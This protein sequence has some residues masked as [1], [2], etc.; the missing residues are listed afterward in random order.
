MRLLLSIL[1]MGWQ[2]HAAQAQELFTYT[3]P[4]SNMPAKNIGIRLTSTIMYDPVDQ[5]NN[6]HLLPELMVGVS[7]NWMMHAEGFFSSRSGQTRYEGMG[8][9]GKW[10]FYSEDDVHTHL[11][12]AMFTRLSWNKSD[13]HQEA[14]DL[15][16]HN[17]GAEA[18]L[19]L[20]KLLHKVALSGS[21]SYVRAADNGS[22][23]KWT[24]NIREKSAMNFTASIGKLF[25]PTVYTGYR[26]TNVNGM[27]ELMGQTNL[28]T[29]KTFVDLAPVVQ[30]VF[31][32][33]MRLDLSYRFTVSNQLSRTTPEGWLIR[34]DY[35]WFNAW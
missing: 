20:T 11:R 26:Q 25:L 23:N 22:G 34:F 31:L 35:N 32:S 15:N 33:K 4:A 5:S 7:K 18:G 6:I 27:V 9:Y 16:G 19:I 13:L 21:A 29:G 24:R 14:I 1:F 10:R 28:H 12:A 3:E 17:T 8:F 30:F 2:L